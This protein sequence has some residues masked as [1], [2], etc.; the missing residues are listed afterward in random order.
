MAHRSES[1][2]DLFIGLFADRLLAELRHGLPRHYQRFDE[3]L[4]ALR[5]R[6]DPMRQFTVHAVR[7][8][9][10]ACRFDALTVDTPMMRIMKA[11]VLFV[12]RH[13]RSMATQR[14]LAELRFRLETD[15]LEP[16]M[17]CLSPARVPRDCGEGGKYGA[18]EDEHRI[19]REATD[20]QAGQRWQQRRTTELE[21]G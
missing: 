5:G 18:A 9:R 1:L 12:A 7:P 3:D 20:R 8:D 21:G 6:L 2:P 19:D 17:L 13:T 10:L 4:R 11:C 14:K 16:A 15:C